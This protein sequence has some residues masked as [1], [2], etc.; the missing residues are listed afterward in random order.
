MK[1]KMIKITTK[2]MSAMIAASIVISSTT[3]PVYAAELPT[4]VQETV[5]ETYVESP[6]VEE[7]GDIIDDEFAVTEGWGDVIDD[8]FAVAPEE[9]PVE[10]E[11]RGDVIDDEFAAA[12]EAEAQP[13]EE[14][15]AE[16]EG[17]GDVIDDEFAAAPVEEAPVEEEGR[18][19][20]IDDE[21]VAA[22]V[23]ETP[24]EEEGR[25]D[26]IDDEFAVAPEDEAAIEAVDVLESN[27]EDLIAPSTSVNSF[28]AVG[29][30]D[31]AQGNIF[32]PTED[33]EEIK[34]AYDAT[35]VDEKD[36]SP[37]TKAMETFNRE[38]NLFHKLEEKVCKKIDEDNTIGVPEKELKKELTK[39]GLGTVN[40]II[41]GDIID[42]AGAVRKGTKAIECFSKA[43]DSKTTAG[44]VL[45]TLEGV[46]NGLEGV[47]SA[48]PGGGL[49]VSGVETVGSV[50]KYGAVKLVSWF[51]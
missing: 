20:I 14:A 7:Q 30:A 31:F 23:E 43:M 34:K 17:Q 16:E 25:G 2:V 4:E 47:V 28:V 15:P 35:N 24:A 32:E 46:K 33:D 12:P 42:G 49:V 5:V 19:D 38:T 45:N 11:G 10:E 48:F 21:F 6:V 18:G 3:I 51:K 44:A 50:L 9:A 39:T 29:T 1:N 26:V 22:P 13:V 41:T 27:S 8:E 40:G 37:F 36:K